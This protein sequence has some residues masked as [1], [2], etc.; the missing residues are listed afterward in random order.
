MSARTLRTYRFA[1]PAQW[2]LCITSRFD[3]SKDGL[4]P[5]TRL[6]PYAVYVEGAAAH[7]VPPAAVDPHDEPFWLTE[8]TGPLGCSPRLVIDRYWVWAFGSGRSTVTR[9]DCDTLQP[10]LTLDVEMEVRDIASDGREGIWILAGDF[11]LHSDCEGRPRERH[12]VRCEA[13]QPVQLGSVNRGSQ[14]VLLADDRTRL[15]FVDAASGR[16]GVVKSLGVLAPAW[17]VTEMA[18]DGRDRIVLW[19]PQCTPGSPKYLLFVLDGAGGTVDGPISDIFNGPSVTTPRPRAYDKIHVAVHRQTL[20]FATD[21]GLWRLDAGQESGA[22]ESESTL[23]TPALLSPD[24]TSDRGWLRAEALIDLPAGAALDADV[25]TSDDPEVLS[26]AS[27]IAANT[28]R[29]SE[30]KQEAIW[31]LFDPSATRSYAFTGPTSAGQAIAIPLLERRDR[32]L[33]LR[34][35]VITPPG[36]TPSPLRELRVLYPNLSIMQ[37]LPGAFQGKQNDARGALRSIAGVLEATTQQF[38]ERI[39]SIG[40]YL[41]AKNTPEEWLDYLGRWLDLPW[42]DELPATAKR[43][44]LLHAGE[45]LDLRGTRAG[46]MTLLRCIAGADAPLQVVDLTVDYQTVRLGG[47]GRGGAALPALLAGASLRTPTL[48]DKAVLGRA[49]LCAGGDPLE[50]LGP[51]LRIRIG[52]SRETRKEIENILRNVLLQYVP[53]GI[54]LSIAWGPAGSGVDGMVLDANGPGAL[55]KDSEIGRTVLGGRAGGRLDEAGLELGF[56]LR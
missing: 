29:T 4:I 43:Q 52:V 11:L 28:S 49:R 20:W 54:A 44:L 42:D 47:C 45:I 18:A 40:K 46:L 50:P 8:A 16:I 3:A 13:G 53:A 32:W 51:A 33:W 24:T 41:D 22:K 6:G 5:S 34:L 26:K 48:G 55:G 37:Y 15:L 25:V 27:D 19:G 9:Y 21:T 23:L 10:D 14:L 38:D 2:A 12:R 17:V 31:A 30:Q 39:S 7:G 56:R 35:S 1:T 36:V